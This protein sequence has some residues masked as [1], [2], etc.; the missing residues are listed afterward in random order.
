LKSHGFHVWRDWSVAGALYKA[1]ENN[2]WGCPQIS[3]CVRPNGL[4]LESDEPI[5]GRQVRERSYL[6]RNGQES[7]DW[8]CC[9]I[10]VDG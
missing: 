2:G 7:A 8:S 3:R 10:A 1:E 6:E 5:F 9:D 4:S